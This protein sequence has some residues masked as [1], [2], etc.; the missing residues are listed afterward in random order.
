MSASVPARLRGLFEING[1][2]QYLD[3]RGSDRGN[4]LLLIVHGGPGST[5]MPFFSHF[6]GKL[7]GHLIVAHW[8]QRGTGRSYSSSIDRTTM[9]VEQF[10]ADGREVVRLLLREFGKERLFILGHSWGSILATKMVVEDPSSYIAYIGTGQIGDMPRSEDEIYRAMLAQARSRGDSRAQRALL[11]ISEPPYEG[12]DS[13]DI[14][15]VRIV[16]KYVL[17][18]GC[19]IHRRRPSSLVPAALRPRGYPNAVDFL[20]RLQRGMKFTQSLMWAEVSRTNLLEEAPRLGVPVFILQGEFDYQTSFRCAREYFDALA[21]PM[22][23]FYPFPEAAHMLPFEDAER[24]DEIL[25]DDILPRF[26]AGR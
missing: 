19:S 20:L 4:P 11:A 21:S 23:E 24:F 26:R 10:V 17:K 14:A 13:S 22:K 1:S 8:E 25:I 7:E 18:Y 9:N 5:E 2:R 6:N 3:A 12:Y 16:R 15:K